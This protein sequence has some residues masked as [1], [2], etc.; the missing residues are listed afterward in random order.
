VLDAHPGHTE[1]GLSSRAVFGV[2]PNFPAGMTAEHVGHVIVTSIL[3]DETAL[4][5]DRFAV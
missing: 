3:A 2:A 5:S 1:T 4:P